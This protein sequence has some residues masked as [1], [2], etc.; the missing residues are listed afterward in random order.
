MMLLYSKTSMDTKTHSLFLRQ[1][2][3]INISTL[4]RFSL[5]KLLPLSRKRIRVIVFQ[6]FL[7]IFTEIINHI[8]NCLFKGEDV[9]HICSWPD[10]KL[11]DNMAF[12]TCELS[13]S[14]RWSPPIIPVVRNKHC[15]TGSDSQAGCKL[16]KTK[17]RPI[18]KGCRI[19]DYD[20]LIDRSFVT[21]WWARVRGLSDGHSHLS[22]PPWELLHWLSPASPLWW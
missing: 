7:F 17:A 4:P 8:D 1:N 19:R 16:L 18:A 13:V 20:Y 5:Q 3:I 9:N 22:L 12:M 10:I 15:A 11:R 21:I 2:C 6:M 14:R